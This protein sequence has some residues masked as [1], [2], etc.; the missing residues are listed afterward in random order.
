VLRLVLGA[1]SAPEVLYLIALWILC[2]APAI[3]TAHT[4]VD[5]FYGP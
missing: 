3:V 1:L 5:D 4:F 2:F